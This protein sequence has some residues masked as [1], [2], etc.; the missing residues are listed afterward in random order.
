MVVAQQVLHGSP[1]ARDQ[2]DPDLDPQLIQIVETAIQE[3][4]VRRYQTLTALG[5]ALRE[6]RGHLESGP[7]SSRRL[8][9]SA[10]VPTIDGG[11]TPAPS[12]ERAALLRRREA[13][14]KQHLDDAA[15][16][17][18]RGMLDD[19]QLAGLRERICR[20][21]DHWNTSEGHPFKWT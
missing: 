13:Q 10:S 16:A 14:L 21:I 4:P 11:A 17:L 6:V 8:G 12:P 3:D 5:G 9:D 2:I 7:R 1:V 18:Q 19:V 20:F 15:E